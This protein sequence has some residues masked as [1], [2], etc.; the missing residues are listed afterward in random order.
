[1][2][3]QFEY[4]HH[5]SLVLGKFRNTREAEL[6][7]MIDDIGAL[8]A[9]TADIDAKCAAAIDICELAAADQ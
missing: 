1:V 9:V 8:D 4:S 7:A 2:Y 6:F 3:E 5:L